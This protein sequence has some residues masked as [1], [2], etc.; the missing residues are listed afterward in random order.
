MMRKFLIVLLAA[1]ELG[2]LSYLALVTWLIS[3]WF[4]DDAVAAGMSATDWYR[5]AAG[6]SFLATLIACLVGLSVY[7][8]NRFVARKI[9]MP[10]SKVP[11]MSALAF[12]GIVLCAGLAGA[13]QFAIEKPFM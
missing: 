12:G 9:G 3:V 7:A 6:R 13:V 5:E 4:L 1:C 10:T 2:A 8:L 11:R